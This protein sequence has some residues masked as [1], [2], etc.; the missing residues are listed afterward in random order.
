M[1]EQTPR[2]TH[3]ADSHRFEIFIGDERVGLADYERTL[4]SNGAEIH[5]VHTEVSPQHQGKNLAAI[6]TREAFAQIRDGLFGEVKVWPVCSYTVMYMQ[7]H[8]ETHDLLAGN[9]DDAVA[10]C[11]VPNV[12]KFNAEHGKKGD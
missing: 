6:L 7:R 2:V 4:G 10:A 8:P 1:T 11:R 12:A 5:F 9:L 3:N